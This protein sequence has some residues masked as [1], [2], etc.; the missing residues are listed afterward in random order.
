M[1]TPG[2]SQVNINRGKMA[3]MKIPVPPPEEQREL[4]GVLFS[5]DDRSATE[6]NYLDQLR[7]IKAALMSVLLTGEVRVK[8]DQAETKND[9]PPA[10]Q[11]QPERLGLPA[12]P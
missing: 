11:A 4:V 12:D 7:S 2:V 1:A 3:A 9:P 10:R 6:C 5:A 8:P